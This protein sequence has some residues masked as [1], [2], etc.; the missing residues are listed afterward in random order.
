MMFGGTFFR[1][2]MFFGESSD[3]V[4]GQRGLTLEKPHSIGIF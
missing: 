3:K 2:S 1:K 4:G